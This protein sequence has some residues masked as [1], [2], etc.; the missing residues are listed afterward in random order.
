MQKLQEE[1]AQLD[2]ELSSSSGYDSDG[3]DGRVRISERC[4]H[5]SDSKGGA[6]GSTGVAGMRAS[7]GGA[8]GSTPGA[9][10]SKVP[11]DSKAGAA[12]S[13]TGEVK[14]EVRP[15]NPRLRPGLRAV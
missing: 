5:V 7:K 2:K 4:A 12:G 1:L 3:G 10:G 11:A 14:K 8:A 15:S 9:A 6:A 13:T